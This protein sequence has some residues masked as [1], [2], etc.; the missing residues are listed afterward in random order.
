[1]YERNSDLRWRGENALQVHTCRFGVHSYQDRFSAPQSGMAS[2]QSLLS[3]AGRCQPACSSHM[4]L[5]A[6]ISSRITT[7]IHVVRYYQI[8]DN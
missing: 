5:S 1:M 7:G 3:V 6:C 4:E 2:F 8:N